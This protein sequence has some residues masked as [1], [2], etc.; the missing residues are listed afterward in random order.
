MATYTVKYRTKGQIRSA[1]ISA[2]D[3]AAAQKQAKRFGAVVSVERDFSSFGKKGMTPDER[4]TFMIRLSTMLASRV[5]T[6]EALRLLRNSFTGRIRDASSLLLE[7]IEGGTDLPTAISEDRQN[8]PGPVG[9][10][11]K[12]GAKGG[13]MYKTLQDAAEFEHKL[14]QV[15]E[16][17]GRSIIGS[18]VGFIFAAGLVGIS[19]FYVG[20]EIMKMGLV[21]NQKD[22]VNVE[23][24]NTLAQVVG[25]IISVGAVILFSFMWLATMGRR[26]F[27]IFADT[28]ILKVP[29]YRDIVL[30]HDNYL[31]LRR[32]AL[33][34]GGGVR[35][36][37]ALQSAI[38]AAKPGV[39]RE[40]LRR[41]H[42][43]LRRG[44]RWSNAMSTLHPTDR[45]AL[46]LASDREQVSKNLD[47]IAEQYQGLYIRLVNNFAPVLMVISAVCV[48]L[49]GVV[50]FGQS[51]L[52]MLQIAASILK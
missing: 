3:N 33:M 11:I 18:V 5:S 25:I 26:F 32:L 15:K 37:E 22:S 20:P 7:K 36:E 48:S 23:R 42:A 4:Y 10:I 45:A 28:I 34:I 12:V 50:L 40:D 17:S 13:K 14:H 27:P 21:Q 24:V 41:A 38:E 44:E 9:L 1:K 6:A 35:V 31:V 47:M 29:F 49:A 39:L 30:S 43:A 51:V 52:P 19:V 8:F 16:S 46:A 2:A